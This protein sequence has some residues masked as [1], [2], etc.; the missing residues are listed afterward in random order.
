MNH[1]LRRLSLAAV[2]PAAA[3]LGLTPAFAQP[4]EG[5][6][7]HGPADR[8]RAALDANG[9]HELDEAELAA[10]SEALKSLDDDGNGRI[11]RHEFR[12]PM[13]PP[14][15]G[16]GDRG[17]DAGPP[18]EGGPEF[19]R[20]REGFRPEGERPRRERPDGPPRD[21]AGPRGRG[22]GPSPERFV[23]RA[24]TFDAD[25][26]GKLDRDE[27]SRFASDMRERMTGSP[28]GRDRGAGPPPS[29]SPPPE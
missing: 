16:F 18:R 25:G 5:P 29:E 17:P 23:E 3:L 9:D 8:L 10:A 22:Q 11:D 28:G 15:R 7:L 24:M 26:D 1:R 21:G 12:P 20:P 6:P 4:P 14:P 13:P 27:L 2:V 19:R